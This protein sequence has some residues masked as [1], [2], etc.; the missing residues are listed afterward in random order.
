MMKVLKFVVT[1]VLVALLGGCFFGNSRYDMPDEDPNE[2]YMSVEKSNYSIDDTI[3]VDV[4]YSFDEEVSTNASV[5]VVTTG[6]LQIE[7]SSSHVFS[8]DSK[9]DGS[10]SFIFDNSDVIEGEGLIGG[11]L[12]VYDET[13]KHLYS[14]W[15]PTISYFIADGK[16]Y[17]GNL[18]FYDLRVKHLEDIYTQGRITHEEYITRLDELSREGTVVETINT[19]GD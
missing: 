4:V 3:K 11:S 12:N 19:Q 18:G 6:V 14:A 16:I 1:L 2:V 10:F 13:G 9:E 17:L 5:E 8:L 7:G 15:A